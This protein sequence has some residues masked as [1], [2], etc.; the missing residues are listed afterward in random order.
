MGAD[1]VDNY[2]SLKRR[3][4]EMK[5]KQVRQ[6]KLRACKPPLLALAWGGWHGRSTLL[7]R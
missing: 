3:G 4:K 7:R 2:I 1:M 6:G 5:V